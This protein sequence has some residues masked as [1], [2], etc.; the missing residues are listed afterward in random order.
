MTRASYILRQ[1]QFLLGQIRHSAASFTRVEKHNMMQ[2]VNPREQCCA[3]PRE[4]F[5]NIVVHVVDMVDH[6]GWNNIVHA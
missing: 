6:A 1:S 3:A 4:H 2:V 5:V